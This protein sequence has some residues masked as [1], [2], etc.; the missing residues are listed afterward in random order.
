MIEVSVKDSTRFEGGWGLYEF[1]AEAGKLKPQAD[2]LP[3]T[4]GCVGCH[5]DKA[6]TDHVFTQ[7]YPILRLN[8]G[9]RS[10]TVVANGRI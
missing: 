1:A 3:Q 2:A 6:E 7:F 10:S 4:V 8:G 9:A 5:R